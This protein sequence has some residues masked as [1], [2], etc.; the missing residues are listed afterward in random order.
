M[1]HAGYLDIVQAGELEAFSTALREHAQAIVTS[2]ITGAESLLS[3]ERARF[4]AF[5]ATPTACTRD[6]PIHGADH[7]L[8]LY[9]SG[10]GS[11][12]V[13]ATQRLWCSCAQF[14]STLPLPMASNAPSMPIVPI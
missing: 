11:S 2:E 6:A 9:H 10:A 12:F 1:P 13:S 7:P 8:V 5:L 3:E 4:D 14:S